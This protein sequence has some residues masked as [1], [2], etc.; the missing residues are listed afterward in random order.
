MPFPFK[1]SLICVGF[2]LIALALVLSGAF[3]RLRV[4]RTGR[5]FRLALAFIGALLVVG[6]CVIL[7]VPGGERS[8]E[9]S[10]G[11][12]ST[13]KYSAPSALSLARGWQLLGTHAI[14]FSTSTRC[15][16]TADVVPGA[17]GEEC[18]QNNLGMEKLIAFPDAESM[19]AYFDVTTSDTPTRRSAC[20]SLQDLYVGGGRADR[21]V[22]PEGELACFNR[23]GY[24]WIVWT[25][26]R[27]HIADLAKM[28]VPRPTLNSY[29]AFYKWTVSGIR[30]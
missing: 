1:V 17:V 2:L 3:Q 27:Y 13:P 23:G 6:S 24:F 8:V 9:K 11:R 21:S 5:S 14:P 25:Y 30:P 26:D 22:F 12:N 28:A 7:L 16:V 19:H 18:V 4:P 29:E 20:N 10:G 15:S